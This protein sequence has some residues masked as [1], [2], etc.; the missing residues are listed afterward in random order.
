M[1]KKAPYVLV[2]LACAL[3][4]AAGTA[5]ADGGGASTV[6]F[7]AENLGDA[8]AV[9]GD[10]LFGVSFDMVSP[11]GEPL[12]TGMSCVHSFEGCSFAAGCRAT[13]RATF[14]LDFEE[15]S[16]SAAVVL[17]EVWPTD[18]SFVQRAKGRIIG[19]TGV[20]DDAR[21]RVKGGGTAVLTE[22]G[23]DPD[24]VFVVRLNSDGDD[25]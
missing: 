13:A 19:G 7:R 22:Q 11:D 12:G 17:R 1:S 5:R 9:C 8:T 23:I 6:V 10:V 4:L 18:F 21:G 25:D 14:V 15:G 24:L 20:F 2:A 16:L 3:G